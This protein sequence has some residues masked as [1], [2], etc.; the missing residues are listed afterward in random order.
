ML[1][2]LIGDMI[3]SIY[4]FNNKRSKNIELF[5]ERYELT[6]DSIMTLAA[7]ECI[8]NRQ[9]YNE[10]KIVETY[11]KWGRAYP[12]RGYGGAFCHW[13]FSDDTKPYYSYGNGAAMRVS[14]AGWYGRTEEEVKELA[15]NLT[16]VT[17]NHP[18]GLKG[19]EVTAMCVYYAR[20]GKSKEFIK[21]YVSKYYNLDFDYEDLKKN[22]WFN[23]TC[24]DTVPQAIYCF[25]ISTDFENCIKTT[26]SIGGDCD[27]TAAISC[28]IAEAYYK[29]IDPELARQVLNKLPKPK[30]GCN[31]L[32][33]LMK[34]FSDKTFYSCE[35]EELND[36][37][38]LLGIEYLREGERYIEFIHSKSLQ[39]IAERYTYHEMGYHFDAWEDQMSDIFLADLD[40]TAYFDQVSMCWCKD[41]PFTTTEKILREMLYCSEF[42]KVKEMFEI[43]SKLSNEFYQN[44]SKLRLTLFNNPKEAFRY[45][46]ENYSIQN[47]VYTELFSTTHKKREINV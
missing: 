28:A 20:I 33:V 30:N 17:H 9:A 21:E 38:Y 36:N 12:N 37:S 41:E 42:D 7:C 40:L 16:A 25:L 14:A 44:E 31:P 4:E 32:E 22:Y 8:L 29:N 10:E 1:G 13:L 18:E 34:F 39:S 5:D 27:T 6:D 46:E 35:N 3:G 45:L 47:R 24:Q 26:I 15:Y 11:K 19:A 43:L 23:E 2:A